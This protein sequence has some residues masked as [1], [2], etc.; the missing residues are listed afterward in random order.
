MDKTQEFRQS[1]PQHETTFRHI[2]EVNDRYP[3]MMT[4]SDIAG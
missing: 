2:A 4:I 3:L 1:F